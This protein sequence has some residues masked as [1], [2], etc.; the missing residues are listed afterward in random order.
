M[1]ELAPIDV[2]LLPIAGWGPRL[3]PGH[4]GVAEAVQA[5]A[6]LRPR[7][8]VPIHWG[9]LVPVGMHLRDWSYLTRP[10]VAFEEQA[11]QAHPEVD[12]RILAPG[13]KL[14]L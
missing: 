9:S 2:A 1:A 3:G 12:V 13:E 4:M 6:L 8:V 10:A 7:I 14:E 11:R 5:L